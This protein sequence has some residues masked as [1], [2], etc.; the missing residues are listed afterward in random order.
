MAKKVIAIAFS[1]LHLNN[2]A[3]F[4]SDGRRTL[5]G[6]DVL[7]RIA[8]ICHHKKC[9]ALFCGDLF[10]K[11]ENIDQNLLD[12]VLT[13]FHN[14]D[15]D[16]PEFRCYAINGNHDLSVINHID[17]PSSG[18]V[19]KFSRIFNWLV[20]A[21]CMEFQ[22]NKYR[23]LGIP[24]IDHNHGL[25]DFIKRRNV[26]I[27][28]LHTDYPGAK[29]TDGRPVDS[30]ENLNINLL[31]PFKLV[32]CGHIHKPQ[33]LGKKVY[34]VGA[35]QQQRRTDRDCKMGYLEI[36]DDLSVKFK[37]WEDYPKFIDV[38]DENDIN[39][40]DGNYYTVIPKP[41]TS[42]KLES[43]HKITKQLTKKQLARRYMKQ[44]GDKNK[45]RL[46]LLT[47]VLTKGE[48]LC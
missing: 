1:D 12:L 10:H 14:I 5:N 43:E 11:P 2:W 24:Y 7:Y 29:D 23:A 15:V 4:N 41:T 31:K 21:D 6:F 42:K 48:E 30:V 46:K 45:A 25:N 22:I 19:T 26:D 32:L 18:W 34:M 33:R 13:E 35:P 28:L 8:N 20:K 37:Y 9:P 17:K 36:Y 3:K 40:D 39:V 27:L 16:Y 38:Y 44:K 47:K